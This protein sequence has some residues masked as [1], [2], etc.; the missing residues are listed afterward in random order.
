MKKIIGYS[1]IILA[2]TDA[3]AQP[4]YAEHHASQTVDQ[5]ATAITNHEQAS[6]KAHAIQ[7]EELK[8]AQRQIWLHKLRKSALWGI[9][10]QHVAANLHVQKIEAAAK[11]RE[12]A[13]A[14]A[15]QKAAEEAQ[16]LAEE[17]EAQASAS[18]DKDDAPEQNTEAS[19]PTET[20]VSVGQ[21]IKA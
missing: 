1:I 21:E 19:S 8:H 3:H 17:K 2:A 7:Q 5:L 20:A 4:W 11:A 13:A 6:R 15:A 18:N 14:L 9:A 12:E 10:A 16:R